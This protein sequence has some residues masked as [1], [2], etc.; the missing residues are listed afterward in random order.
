MKGEN[1]NMNKFLTKIIGASLAIA[2]MIGVGAGIDANKVA[3]EVNADDVAC[4]MTGSSN[5]TVKEAS[6]STGNAVQDGKKMNKGASGTITV[7][8]AAGSTTLYYHA[9]AWNGEAQTISLSCTN[10]TLSKSS[11][12]ITAHSDVSG[13]KTT[14]VIG[15]FTNYAYS[16][17]LT[18]TTSADMVLTLT[19]ASN[20]RFVIFYAYYTTSG[21]Q[22]QEGPVQLGT[23]A[24]QYN[25]ESNKVTWAAVPHASSY[26][27]SVGDEDHYATAT[28]P[29]DGNFQAGIEYTVY[30]KAIGDGEDYSDSESGSVHFAVPVPFQGV[31]Y[32]LCTSTSDLEAGAKYIFTSGTTGTIK[33]MSTE[34]NNNNR[35]VTNVSVDAQTHRITSTE[36]TLVVEL[37]GSEDHWTFETTN[38][39][40]NA[41]YFASSGSNNYLKIMENAGEATISFTNSYAV[42]HLGPSTTND[43]VRY[44]SGSTLFSCYSSGQSPVYMWKEFKEL[45]HLTV[46]GELEKTTYYDSETF[47]STGLTVTA[48]Y[49]D[50][51]S[52]VLGA[53]EV[54]WE[55]LVANMTQIRGSYTELGVTKYTNYI[56]ITVA[57]D[58]LSTVTLSGTMTS[59][60]FTTDSWNNG[61]LVV[62]ANYASGRN[63]V[64]TNEATFAYY[65]DSAMQN[66][67]ATPAD[68]GVGNDQTIYVKATYD[69]VSNT[70]GYAQTVTV[71]IEHGSVESDPL[72]VA[73]AVEKGSALANRTET[74]KQYYI[75][76]VVS[77]I[78]DNKLGEEGN[79]VFFWLQNGETIEGF[80]VYNITPA[81]GCTNYNDM[82][83]GAEVLIKCKIKNYDSTIEVGSA[84]SLLSISYTAPTLTGIS[85]NKSSLNLAV[86][87]ADDLTVSP[88][89]IGAELGDVEWVSSNSEVATVNSEGHVVAVANGSATITASAGGF[90][91]TCL[92]TV[93]S[94]AVMEYTAGTTTN[95]A[96]TGNAALVNLD[97]SLFT[98]DADKGTGN[99]F[100]GLNQANEIRL[101]AGGSYILVTIVPEYTISTIEIEFVSGNTFV[102]VYVGSTEISA[103]AD[104]SY[105]INAQS[106]KLLGNG[107][108]SKI[109]CV[110]IMYRNATATEKINRLETRNT[111]SYSDYHEGENNTFT[112]DN[113]GIRFGGLINKDLWDALDTN[114]HL[115]QGYG[116]MISYE[117]LGGDTFEYYYNESKAGKTVEQT[118]DYLF[119]NDGVGGNEDDGLI[120][121]KDYYFPLTNE[122]THPAFATDAQKAGQPDGQYYIW[123]LYKGVSN[124]NLTKEYTAVAYI[125][126]GNELV[127]LTQTTASAS[128][129]AFDLIDSGAYADDAFGGSLA[130][131]AS[132]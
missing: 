84:K 41:G 36:Q 127:F 98:V 88:T 99:N 85:L 44:N 38:Y 20:K 56:S 50:S 95:M 106:F 57:A 28:S 47:D 72:T 96:A 107:G 105:S 39:L 26:Q 70:T 104:G 40:G 122:K 13:T 78:E 66:G 115:I 1:L 113:V 109:E 82:K 64:V 97:A 132:L 60:Y 51:S 42:I 34:S 14:Y 103:G 89:P 18:Q 17:E 61:S 24:P 69:G 100:P 52:K 68:L 67:I 110:N 46:T 10:A 126:V 32:A 108:T 94:K 6:N 119:D 4:A 76:G 22:Q 29:Y 62:T 124:A 120:H 101:Y 21:G 80:E 112:Y 2:M 74:S 90:T 79:Y 125:R 35:K 12:D 31:Q 129:L 43:L 114:E 33:A 7:P 123:N 8:A 11:Q 5:V 3:T 55:P 121:G 75:Q 92:V 23:P 27:V 81:S 83:L 111:L 118:V 102:D 30:V 91:A 15:S 117:D 48:V 71:T 128:S 9:V 54:V 19:A 130:Y 77:K 86:A 63:N 53:D 58:S 131:L 45:D 49:T 65:S 25:S 16:V 37:G 116:V 73:E 59:T 87:E 93:S